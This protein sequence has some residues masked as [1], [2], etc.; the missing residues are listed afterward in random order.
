MLYQN[1]LYLDIAFLIEKPWNASGKNLEFSGLLLADFE[2]SAI[3]V[4]KR[5]LKDGVN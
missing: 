5:I 3:A 2:L 4:Q 1:Y